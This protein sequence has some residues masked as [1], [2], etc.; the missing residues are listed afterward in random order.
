MLCNFMQGFTSSSI[1]AHHHK[2]LTRSLKLHS[3]ISLLHDRKIFR[4]P[5]QAQYKART[6]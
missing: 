4:I 2:H 5:I 6:M 1:L 3:E